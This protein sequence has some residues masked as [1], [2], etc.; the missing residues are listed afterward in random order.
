MA[1]KMNHK[2]IL[3]TRLLALFSLTLI[4]SVNAYAQR[5]LTGTR[6]PAAGS[7]NPRTVIR[8]Q[9]PD[10]VGD[11]EE[12]LLAGETGEALEMALN[13]VAQVDKAG[14]D[15][16]SRYFAHNS[17]CV[18]YTKLGEGEKARRECDVAIEAMPLHWSAWNNR[19]TLRFLAGD[20]EGAQADY[21]RALE[22]APSREGVIDML[23]YNLSLV[24]LKL[25]PLEQQ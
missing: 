24:E 10:V 8:M 9:Q 6:L 1:H 7:A 21:R 15:A 13:F 17:L 4:L 3:L 11:I 5:P 2:L 22:Q 19:G 16:Q 25:L 20:F 18:V 23:R 14:M 12:L